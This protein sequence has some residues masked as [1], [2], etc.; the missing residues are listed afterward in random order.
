M[1]LLREL[2]VS[3]LT[4]VQE[5]LPHDTSTT[6]HTAFMTWSGFV[7]TSP[8]ST[9]CCTPVV[10]AELFL[11]GMGINLSSLTLLR[12]FST[13]NFVK[14]LCL[15]AKRHGAAK[16]FNLQRNQQCAWMMC[17]FQHLNEFLVRAPW[18]SS[19]MVIAMTSATSDTAF[20]TVMV[21]VETR[22]G[23]VLGLLTH[24]AIQVARF[25]ARLLDLSVQVPL[26]TCSIRCE[27]SHVAPRD[28]HMHVRNG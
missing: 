19:S 4:W 14:Y 22:L 13:T 17:G 25:Q 18:V 3:H 16:P 12:V 15:E 21:V 9:P 2:H 10:R 26:P 8:Q 28:S 11:R 27:R 5:P 6:S 24:G 20:T 1:P 7:C 23:H